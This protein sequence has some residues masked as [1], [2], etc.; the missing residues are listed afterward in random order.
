MAL[1]ETSN[2]VPSRERD[3]RAG[4][5]YAL[6]LDNVSKTFV[7]KDY[8]CR[9]ALDGITFAVKHGEMVCVVGPSGCG[10]ST[11]LNIVAGLLKED[12]GTVRVPDTEEESRTRLG[13]ITQRDSLLPWRSVLGNVTLGL[14]VRRIPR[15]E[16]KRM[17]REILTLVGL[18]DVDHMRPAS[19]SGG[20]RKRLQVARSLVCRPSLLL[21][22]EPFG[23]LDAQSKTVLQSEL[24]RWR[25]AQENPATAVFITHDLAE[26][27]T[28][29]ERVIVLGG[30]PSH[31]VHIEHV[32][33]IG[34]RS[35]PRA[36]ALSHEFQRHVET[37]W[38]YISAGENEDTK[39]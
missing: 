20:M 5:E 30:R 8:G 25:L 1:S 26:A 32:D 18:S 17:A 16:R 14:E 33:D 29:G 37:L 27:V 11:V 39:V 31:V 2:A 4:D 38:T 21:L 24:V 15:R 13:Y 12:S 19:L 22:D 6:V 35:D 36:L 10:K 3:Q 28:L 23:A 9:K 34:D 7:G